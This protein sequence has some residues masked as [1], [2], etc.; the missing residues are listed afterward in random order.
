MK[1][2]RSCFRLQ[3]H[4]QLRSSQQWVRRINRYMS[5]ASPSRAGLFKVVFFAAGLQGAI[6]LS[7]L[8]SSPSQ[9]AERITFSLGATIERSISV[10]SLERYVESGEV[11][12]ELAPYLSYIDRLD[13][14]AR[15]QVRAL[16]SQRA[17]LDVVTVA[18]FAY[19][20][21]GDYLLSQAGEVFRTGARLSGRKGLR[22][23]AIVSAADPEEGLTIL[24]VA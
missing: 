1:S 8:F 9:A 10:D 22:G 7:P 4:R 20:P 14:N 17:D 15:E 24:N 23:A 2:S 5:Q 11:T 13:P 3:L 18:Q 12:N 19:T 21:Q 16:L 6:A